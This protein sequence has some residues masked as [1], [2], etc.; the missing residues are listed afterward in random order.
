MDQTEKLLK[1]LTEAYGVTGHE[2]DVAGIIA[3]HLKPICKISYDKL[4]S[5]IAEKRG[6]PKGPKIMLA[7]HMDE[8]GF[9]VKEVTKE[10]FVKFLPRRSCGLE[11]SPLVRGRGEKKGRGNKGYVH[12]CGCHGR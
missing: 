12:R 5:I 3:R 1:E 4:G 9:M 11:G 2:E 7:G 10:G 8:V 6:T